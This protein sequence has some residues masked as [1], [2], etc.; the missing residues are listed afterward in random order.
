M[1]PKMEQPKQYTPEELAEIEMSRTK[2]DASLGDGG[3]KYKFN[4][5][6]EKENLLV[7]GEQINV[8][9]GEF[10]K[11]EESKKEGQARQERKAYFYNT[12]S[13]YVGRDIV[14]L[15]SK[16]EQF[17]KTPEKARFGGS[18]NVT[19]TFAPEIQEI[20]E[21]LRYEYVKKIENDEG[22][23]QETKLSLIDQTGEHRENLFHCSGC[24]WGF[25]HS[26]QRDD[27]T[28]KIEQEVKR[29]REESNK[30]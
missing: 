17:L 19:D 7:T 21:N 30:F 16:N 3:A 9:H 11:I 14:D 10:E 8:K 22:I 29:Q 5:K 2:S 12:V 6:G 1:E 4:E 13:K 26:I 23:P 15:L 18:T 20:L 25:L 24:M 27:L 28:K